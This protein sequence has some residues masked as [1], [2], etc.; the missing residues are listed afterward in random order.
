MPKIQENIFK[1]NMSKFSY[2]T[3][4]TDNAVNAELTID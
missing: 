1:K 2:E 4:T 3:T